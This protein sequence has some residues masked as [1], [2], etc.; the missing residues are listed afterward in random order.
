MQHLKDQVR[1]KILS[2]A[3]TEFNIHGYIDAS[4]RDIA[5]G[6]G[7]ALGSIYRYFKNK[8][9]L[10][11]FLIDPVC[12]KVFMYLCKMR[13]QVE[14]TDLRLDDE[15]LEYV[16]KLYDKIV[17]LIEEHSSEIIIIF[18]RSE[19][20]KFQDIKEKFI[21]LVY[22]ILLKTCVEKVQE[23]KNNSV[24]LFVLATN[25]VDGVSIILKNRYD[26]KTTRIL[27]NKLIVLYLKDIDGR[28]CK[29]E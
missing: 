17:D 29:I 16:S 1:E 23:D 13:D 26:G 19:G 24:I 25:L 5:S 28:L 7:I 8:E 6:A 21:D 4:M 22:N 3:L 12:S 18:N 2:A 11:D 27:I 20:S 14:K 9:A 10:F 15:S